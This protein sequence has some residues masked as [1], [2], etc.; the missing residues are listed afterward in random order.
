M[1]N[2]QN[3]SPIL[4]VAD[5]EAEIKFFERLGFQKVYNSLQYSSELDYVVLSRDG[6]TVHLQ[7]FGE[8]D[9]YGQQVKIWVNDLDAI[10]EELDEKIISYNR[11][12][13]TPW[14]TSE[15][16][17]YSPARHAIYFVEE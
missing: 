9:F 4:P 17:M 5:L 13:N 7:L 12:N 10:G 16:G 15:I 2:L 1:P 14:N 11:R 3:I 6:Q 8:H